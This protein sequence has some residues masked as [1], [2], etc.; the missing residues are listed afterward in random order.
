[1]HTHLD[2]SS[3]IAM[4][5]FISFEPLIGPVSMLLP[6]CCLALDDIHSNHDPLLTL[7]RSRMKL[8]SSL[9]F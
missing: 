6:L 8:G 7:T 2:H 1:M 3:L 4:S 5:Y 9:E